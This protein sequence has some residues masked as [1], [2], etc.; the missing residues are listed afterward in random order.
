M[1][2]AADSGQSYGDTA[3]QIKAEGNAGVFSRARGELIST[4]EIGNAYSIGN[5]QMVKEFE[6][7]V[8][9]IECEKLW[10]KRGNGTVD[11]CDD[12][13]NEDWVPTDHVFISGDTEPLAH[14]GCQC[15]MG[16]RTIKKGEDN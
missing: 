3:K 8:P 13:A 2:E 11:E 16:Y 7:A 12:N 10:I 14:P 5:L 6:K 1:T 15:D 4:T 9:E